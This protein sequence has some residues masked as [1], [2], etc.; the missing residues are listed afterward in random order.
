[1]ARQSNLMGGE[2]AAVHPAGRST[3]ILGPSDSSD[4]GS[5]IQG[6]RDMS[7]EEL[8]SDSDAAGTGERATADDAD[9]DVHEGAD[10]APDRI[11]SGEAN[12]ESPDEE[13]AAQDLAPVTDILPDPGPVDA[14]FKDLAEENDAEA[15]EEAEEEPGGEA[16]ADRNQAPRS[17]HPPKSARRRKPPKP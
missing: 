3:A 15:D 2:R 7:A 12:M 16:G 4:S 13:P 11:D 1:M 17:A 14:D 6:E 8:A 9:R 5:D 10:I